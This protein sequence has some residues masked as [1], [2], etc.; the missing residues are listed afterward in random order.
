MSLPLSKILILVAPV[1]ALAQTPG[2]IRDILER[3]SRLEE[4]NRALMS[5]V[6]ALREQ[7][8]VSHDSPGQMKFDAPD[9]LSQAS[10]N[11]AAPNQPP[12]GERV[13]VAEHRV[14]ELAQTKVEASQRYPIKLTGTLLFNAFLNGRDSGDRQYPTTAST[15]P[16]PSATGA[17]FRQSVIGLEFSGPQWAGAKIGGTLLMDFFA[18]SSA[19]L[20]H[21]VR[22][23]IATMD[24]EWKDTTLSF[25]QDKPIISPRE[26]N[27]L[28]QVG[29][30]PLTGAGNLWLWQPQARIEQ[31][32]RFGHSSGLKL[33]AGVFETAETSVAVPAQY[34]A[35]QAPGRPGYEGRFVFWKDFGAGRRVEIAPGF[36]FSSSHVAGTSVPSDVYSIDWLVQPLSKLQFSGMF[37][38]GKNIAG[39]G[40]LR[41]G[42]SFL[43]DDEIIPIHA[44][45]GWAQISIPLTSRLTF[46]TYSGEEDDRARDLTAG[47]INRNLVTAANIFYRFAPNVLGS[48]EVSRTQ[49]TYIFIGRRLNNHYDLALAYLF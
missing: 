29:V 2:D 32:I 13:D 4:Q 15:T 45:G 40:S 37:F 30:S 21:L 34:A 44:E 27:S 43:G 35:T 48:F 36:H 25:G 19:S 47:A 22:M 28:A 49:T 12:V 9:Q 8:N 31:R 26:P 14:D 24:L 33:Q 41:Q 17:S 6:H 3:L 11:Q 42:Y 10:T 39:L 23:R 18:G 1:C 46:N 38:S 16:G 5:E 20:D 7:L